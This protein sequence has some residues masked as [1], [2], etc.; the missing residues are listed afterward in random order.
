MKADLHVHSKYSRRPSQWI[1]QKINCPESFTEPLQLYKIAKERGMSLVTITDHNTI[2]GAMELA[3]LPDTF[4]SEEV[5]TYFPENGCKIHVLTWDIQER[6]HTEIQRLRESIYDLVPYLQQEKIFHAVAHPLYSI[7][8]RLTLEHFEK[9]LLL[10]RNFELNGAREDLQNHFLRDFLGQLTEQDIQMLVE[11]HRLEPG[12]SQP[13]KKNLT[14]GSDDHSSLNISRRYTQVKGAA[15]AREFLEGIETG[16]AEVLGRGASPQTMAHNLYGIA[17]Q[18][19][20]NKFNLDRHIHKDIFLRFVDRFLQAGPERE[21]GLLSRFY[22]IWNYRRSRARSRGSASV[23]QIFKLESQKLIMDDPELMA[24]VRNGGENNENKNAEKRWFEFVNKVSNKVLMHFGNHLMDHISGGNFF[25]IFN[26]L[27]SAGA[28][29]SMLAPYFV[30]FS[31]FTQDRQL[32]DQIIDRYPHLVR[33]KLR[34]RKD[35]HVAH[36]TDTLYEVNGVAHTLQQQVRQAIQTGKKLT[37]ITCDAENHAKKQG[38]K[39]F[40]PV[41]VYELPVYQEQKLFYPPF[42]EMLN[43]CYEQGFTHIHSATPGP[44]GLAALAISRILKLPI[45]GTYHTSLPQYARYLTGDPNIEDLTWNYVLWYYDHMD[46]IFVPSRSTGKELEEKGIHA[47]KIQLFPRGID[48]ERFHPSKRNGR[49]EKRYALQGKTR[50][51]YVGRVSREKDLHILTNVFKILSLSMPDVCLVVV[52]DGPYLEEMKSELKGQPAVFTGY[53]EGED[54]TEAYASCDLFVFPSTTDTFGN[55]VL[56]AQASGL[57][58]IVTDSGGPQENLIEGK[59]GLIVPANNSE[60]LLDA[61]CS[62]I[63]DPNRLKNMS[64]EARIYMEERSFEKN[65]ERTWQIQF[66][67]K[68]PKPHEPEC[69]LAKAS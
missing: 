18:F 55:V 33:K 60:A 67:V 8:E 15:N 54:L 61:I 37:V 47:D 9:L 14:G 65:F 57:P 4:L 17:Y 58:V 19:Y 59:T 22:C 5:T 10:F 3:H 42:L 11:K 25:N 34:E 31:I 66:Q 6:Q 30:A 16:R 56:E 13:W 41:G 51:I 40:R 20:K 27:G 24:I 36:F 69:P 7:N 39:N 53:L 48:V 45:S 63:K 28:L 2:A 62:L 32:V 29:Y 35:V 1:L 23:Q 68:P 64:R 44:I 49:F 52:G 12:F 43:Y 38:I 46:T 50:L 21:E 26:S